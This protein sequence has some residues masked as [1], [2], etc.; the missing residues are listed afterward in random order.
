[1]E[2]RSVTI[3][4]RPIPKGR[5]RVFRGHAVTPRKTQQAES[6]LLAMYKFQNY[7]KAP[8]TGRVEVHCVFNM[9]I[10]KTWSKHKKELAAQGWINCTVRPDLDN[11]IK[12]V[13]DALNGAAYVD[14]A[15]IVRIHAFKQYSGDYPEGATIV[16]IVEQ[17]MPKDAIK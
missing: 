5:P 8:L 16:D 13:L 6:Q 12:L 1:M 3:E 4:G 10:P 17:E 2:L 14:D 15:Q 11:L 9:P 7:G